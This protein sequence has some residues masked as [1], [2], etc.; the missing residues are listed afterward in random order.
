MVT[1]ECFPFPTSS[2]DDKVPPRFT[3]TNRSKGIGYADFKVAVFDSDGKRTLKASPT[4]KRPGRRL[5]HDWKLWDVD[6][7]T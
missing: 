7:W 3:G 4:L 1:K 5:R 6:W 2:S